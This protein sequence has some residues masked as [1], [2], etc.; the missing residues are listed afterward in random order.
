MAALG[1]PGMFLWAPALFPLPCNTLEVLIQDMR[2]LLRPLLC[3]VWD[4]GLGR[5]ILSGCKEVPESKQLAFGKQWGFVPANWMVTECQAAK[6]T[7][8]LV[9]RAPENS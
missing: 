3:S 7:R 8:S 2:I 5:L 6:E 1:L 9:V 4:C